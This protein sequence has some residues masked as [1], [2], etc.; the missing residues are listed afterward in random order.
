M[1]PRKPPEATRPVRRPPLGGDDAGHQLRLWFASLAYVLVDSLRRIALP[2]TQ[3]AR[4]TAGSIRLK[5]LKIGARVTV[6]VRRIKVAMAS[7]HPW[8]RE[9]SIAHERLSIAAC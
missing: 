3:L 9:F 8:R 4:A 7:A 5:L 6:S 1:A 2:G